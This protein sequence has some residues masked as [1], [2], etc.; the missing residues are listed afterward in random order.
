MAR[1]RIGAM[2]SMAGTMEKYRARVQLESQQITRECGETL[3][4]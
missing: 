3:R 4:R 1:F 2:G